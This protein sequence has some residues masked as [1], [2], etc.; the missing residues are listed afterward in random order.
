MDNVSKFNNLFLEQ[1]QEDTWDYYCKSLSEANV[2]NWDWII[3]TASN[4]EQA[5][6]YEEEI[7]YRLERNLLPKTTKYVVIPDP[8]GKRVGSGG[9]TLNVLKYVYENLE[10]GCTFKNQKILIIHSGGDSKRVP[11]YSANGKLF[12][13]VQRE[14]PDGRTSTL[15]DEFIITFSAIPARMAPGMLVLSGDVLL[16]F[17]PLQVDLTYC[18]SACISIKAPAETGKNHGVFLADKNEV[19]QFLHKM[20]VEQLKAIGATNENNFVNIDTGA[21]YLGYEIVERLFS[22]ITTDVKV[23]SK[24]FNEFVNE[25]ARISFYGDFVYP[26]ATN[27]KLEEYRKQAPE[28]EMCEEL[29]NCRE[30]IWQEL[31]KYNMRIVKLSP[32]E[33]IHFGTTKELQELVSTGIQKYECLGW[34]RKVLCNLSENIEY[35]VNNSYISKDALIEKAAYIENSYIRT[36]CKIGENTIISSTNIENANIPANICINSLILEDSTYV[37]RIYSLT[38]NPK[39]EKSANTPFLNT[40]LE[41]ALEKYNISEKQIWDTDEH[42]LWKANLYCICTSNKESVESALKL[43]N[44]IHCKASQQEAQEYFSKARTSL[45]MSFNKSDVIKMRKEKENIEIK[46]RTEQIIN[47][48]QNKI[49]SDKIVNSIM[50]SPNIKEQLEDILEALETQ[51][52][53]VRYKAYLAISLLLKQIQIPGYS[54][55]KFEECCYNEIKKMITVK[56]NQTIANKVGDDVEVT[57]PIRVNFG[58][59]WSDTPPYC[60]ENGGSVLNIA[61]KLNDDNPIKVQLKKILNKSIILESKDLNIKREFTNIE[62]LKN[63]TNTNDVFALHKASLLITGILL[64]E[65]KTIE[66]IIERIG[67]GIYFSTYVKDIPKGSGLGTSSILSGACLKALYKFM[68]IKITDEELCYKVLEQEQL[69]GTGGGWQDQIG[70]LIPGIKLTT[71]EAGYIQKFDVNKIQLSSKIKEE[72][73]NRL[74]LI[75]TGQRRLAKN[76]LR[77]IMDNVIYNQPDTL[78]TIHKIKKIS[79]EM[80]EALLAENIEKFAELLNKHWTLS[81]KLDKGCSNT[82]IEQIFIAC[83][84]LISAKMICGAGGGGFLQVLLKENVSKKALE[85]RIQEVFQDSGIKV[86]NVTIFEGE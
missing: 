22:L 25:K 75:Y 26:L 48:I 86:Y 4:K 69:M 11:Q 43:Y 21:I 9:A 82:I 24:K 16:V 6:V 30:K 17:N 15:F 80:A 38:D 23:D 12:S 62:E 78:E 29:L 76:L 57:L 31:N 74:A 54:S 40:I 45:Y 47:L 68:D 2:T 10:A 49:P 19:K 35:S 58:G 7:K 81:K 71:T 73:N 34:K 33:F 5:N 64:P 83:D 59:G 66:D 53:E 56:S 20:P 44:I 8:E 84:D 63:C 42:T 61:L 67:S 36:R 72:I 37:T 1:S 13:P 27:S 51:N 79:K 70:G 32:A 52:I 55:M 60:N 18:E 50:A 85:E 77:S 14:L 28:G 65:D 41:N 46:I 3:L 39:I